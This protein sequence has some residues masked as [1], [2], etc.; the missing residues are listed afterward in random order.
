MNKIIIYNL[1][2]KDW[3]KLKTL[4]VEA[5][6]C[7][8]QAFSSTV[9]DAVSYSDDYWQQLLQHENNLYFIATFNGTP[10]GLIR[11]SIEDGGY[12]E[13]GSFYVNSNY[14]NQ[15]IG[16]LLINHITHALQNTSVE[17]AKLNV[18]PSQEAAIHLYKKCGFSVVG[19]EDGEIVMEIQL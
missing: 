12:A 11:T 15:G 14:R 13:I 6:T 3:E 4:R 7:E 18:K 17:K 19:N 1:E 16:T 5:L 8:P 10:V 2:P 9:E